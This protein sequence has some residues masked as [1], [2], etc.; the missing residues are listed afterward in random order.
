VRFWRSRRGWIAL[1]VLVLL[2]LFLIRPGANRLRSRIVN[3]ISMA[4]GRQVDVSAVNLRLFPQPGFDLQDFVVHDDP[5]FSAEP[6]LRAQEVT[7]SLR[8]ASLLRGKLEIARLNLTEPSLNLV[9]NAE[10]R[11]NLEGLV[12]RAARIPAAPTSKQTGEKRP[13]FPYIEAVRGRINFK[14]GLE[15]KP[16]ALTDADYA[17]WQD[18]E[19]AWGMRL[20]AQPLRTDFNLS[21]TG[22]IRVNGSWQRAADLRETPLHFSLQW[23]RAQLGQFT[24]F[25]Y[26]RDKG[27]RGTLLLSATFAGTPSDLNVVTAASVQDFRRFDIVGGGALRLAAQCSG[28]YSSLDHALS[29]V[30]C[31]APVGDGMVTVKGQILYPLSTRNYD[32][33]VTGENLPLQSLIAFARHAKQGLPLDLGGTGLLNASVR[34]LR[35]DNAG[36]AGTVWDGTGEANDLHLQSKL[37]NADLTLGRIPFILAT[38][39][40]SKSPVRLGG[41]LQLPNEPHAEIGPFNLALGRPV[42]VVVRGWA[43][44]SGYSFSMQGDAELQPLLR[45]ARTAGIPVLQPAADGVAK[46]DLQVAGDWQGFAAPRLQGKAQLHSVRA[47]VRGLNG[48]IEITAANLVLSPDQVSVQNLTA[49]AAGTSWRGSL[50]F[51]RPCT[52]PVTCPVRFDLH[53]DEIATDR[54]NELINP[55][56]HKKPW[57]GFL[58][59]SSPNTS[60]LMTL[61]A[62][63]KI[64]AGRLVV[65]KLVANQVSANLEL[66]AGKLRLAAL[67]AEVF[68]GKHTGEWTADFTVK[69]P[70]YSGTGTLDR[71]ALDQ[72]AK[73]MNDAWITGSATV[74]YRVKA[75][76]LET[77][78][79]FASASSTLKLDA[80]DGMFSH[81]VLSQGAGPLQ[82]RRLAAHLSLQDGKFEIQ[83]GKLDTPVGSYQVSGTASLTRILNLKL[84]HEGAPGF[85]ITGTLLE[86]HVSPILSPETRAALKP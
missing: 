12:E 43:S 61:H 60:F 15:K 63:G 18:S 24:K 9:R 5:A 40:T 62:A 49:S 82:M 56:V 13:A 3:S 81:V 41:A 28:H 37:A 21:D 53:A 79:L 39:Q 16:Y 10:G 35:D 48:P 65:R 14:F 73:S 2:A 54:L 67:N 50:T 77:T 31:S 25:A 68:G 30:D 26:G 47:E 33:A 34:L 32:L 52:G 7:A 44:R 85:N 72:F 75:S 23:D 19:N 4:L 66:S 74:A 36:G 57:Y 55:S 83:E 71:I 29:Q 86:P 80:R 6:M 84:T 59:S 58:S 38:S 46:V 20:E 1:G 64:T 42:P 11:W 45:L 22:I 78:A 70:E 51:P 17:F 76:G 27:W 8:I 69:P